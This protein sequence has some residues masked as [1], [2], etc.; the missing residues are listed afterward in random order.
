MVNK[1]NKETETESTDKRTRKDDGIVFAEKTNQVIK[2]MDAQ[3]RKLA[4]AGKNAVR[5]KKI[6]EYNM[7]IDHHIAK[8]EAMK[9]DESATVTAEVGLPTVDDI[10]KASKNVPETE[11][12]IE[13]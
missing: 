7:V 2:G 9:L 8:F 4:S 10:V 11:T 13:E 12:A 1:N 5:G 3:I 6:P